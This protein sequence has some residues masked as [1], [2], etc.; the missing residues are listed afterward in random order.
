MKEI[1]LSL[2]V[3]KPFLDRKVDKVCMYCVT[4][5]AEYCSTEHTVEQF[6]LLFHIR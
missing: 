1:E 3:P 5:D 4:S 6:A 2:A